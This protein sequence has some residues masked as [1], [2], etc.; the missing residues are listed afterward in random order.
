M[1]NNKFGRRRGYIQQHDSLYFYCQ[2]CGEE[3]K[4][5]EGET[6][7]YNGLPTNVCIKCFEKIMKKGG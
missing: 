5:S 6:I 2:K 3:T 4:K 7:V 1:K